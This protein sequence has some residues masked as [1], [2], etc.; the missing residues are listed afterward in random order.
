MPDQL[1]LS[2]VDQ[3]PVRKGGSTADA[4]RETVELA[5]LAESLGY[6]RYWVAEHHNLPGFAG[7]SPEVLIGQI[8]ARTQTIRVGSGGVML[9]HYSALRVAEQFRVL[10]AFYPGRIDLGLGRAPGGDGRTATALAYPGRVR[11]ISHYPQQIDDLACY[12]GDAMP[13]GH[14]FEQVRAAPTSSS[15]SPELW[16]LGSGFDSALMAAERGLPFS[17][18]HFF[19]TT[20]GHGPAVVNAYREH[21]QAD[22]HHPEPRVNV[23]A[24]VVCAPSHDEAERLASSLA[25]ARLRLA[26]G[27]PEAIVSPEEALAYPYRPEE[28]DFVETQGRSSIV[29]DPDRVADALFELAKTYETDDLGVVTICFDFEARCRSYELIAERFALAGAAESSGWIP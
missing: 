15:T 13:A 6:H 21:F 1:V 7:T 19:G 20:A 5:V 10:E 23:S 2:V 11:D 25:Y 4:L 16:L 12:L 14:P 17:F 28:R 3:S 8:A 26:L 24:Q 9:S 22:E 29:G 27:A 18:A